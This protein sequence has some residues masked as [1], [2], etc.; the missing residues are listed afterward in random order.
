[1]IRLLLPLLSF[2]QPFVSLAVKDRAEWIIPYRSGDLH[3]AESA[4]THELSLIGR[5]QDTA[6]LHLDRGTIRFAMGDAEE[7]CS[8]L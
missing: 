2:F 7:A 1:M 6:W 4:A 8:R 5:C 3:H